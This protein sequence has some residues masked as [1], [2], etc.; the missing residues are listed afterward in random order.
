[1]L[2]RRKKLCEEELPQENSTLL[3]PFLKFVA[4]IN[5]ILY[6]LERLPMPRMDRKYDSDPSLS[7]GDDEDLSK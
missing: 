2:K 4:V 6:N 5:S 7:P 3:S 1:M